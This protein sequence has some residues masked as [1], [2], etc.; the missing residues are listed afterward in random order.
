MAQPSGRQI[1]GGVAIGEGTDH[2]GAPADLAHDPLERIVGEDASPM[3]LWERVVR[4]G[5]EHGLFDQGAA[6]GADSAALPS[7]ML[8]SRA[9]T[10]PA[11]RWA[12]A[13]SSWAW[14]ALS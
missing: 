8:W 14:I 12:A 9:T 6:D 13:M 11:L 1:D 2:A 3:L 4:Q 7:L 10:S 5:L